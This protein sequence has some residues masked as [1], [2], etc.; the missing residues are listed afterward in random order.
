MLDYKKYLGY[1]NYAADAHQEKVL[2]TAYALRGFPSGEKNPYFTHTLWCSMM[3][4]CETQLPENIR[5]PGSEALL[6]HDVLEDTSASLPSSLSP[7]VVRLIKD[8]TFNCFDAEVSETLANDK[9]IHLLKL[10]DK[11]ATLYD[12]A[13][14][15]VMYPKW[16][17]FTESL[18]ASV[19]KNYGQL[20]IVML[21]KELTKKYRK[22]I[23]TGTLPKKRSEA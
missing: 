21:A 13:L 4:L 7:E 5:V 23:E 1:V 6:F 3:I 22:M 15:A 10:Y 11:V 16:L 2:P 8:M 19:E 9:M 20:H 17:D 14:P 18:T 12:G